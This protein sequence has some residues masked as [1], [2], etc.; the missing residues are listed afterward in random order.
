VSLPLGLQ[1][2]LTLARIAAADPAVL[3]VDEPT[4]DVPPDEAHA[5]EEAIAREAT[6]RAVLFITHDVALVRRRASWTVL[7]CDARVAASCPARELF[8]RPPNEL[9]RRFVTSGNCWRSPADDDAPPAPARPSRRSQPASFRWVVDGR[10]GG[11]ARP[12]LV[13]DEDDELA[14]L[15]DLGVHTLV[16]LEEWAFPPDRLARYG[17]RGE[18]LPMPDMGA[19]E[20]AAAWAMCEATAR[21]LAAGQPTVFHCKAGLGR[22]GTMLAAHLVYG[23]M[24]ALHALEEVRSV[25]TGYVQSDE[26]ELFLEAFARHCRRTEARSGAR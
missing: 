23:G 15:R 10:L 14:A 25:G 1:R 26:Q 18:H 3:L 22:T 13:G 11:M 7:L 12:G 16:T 9:C 2:R 20:V 6:R 4:R 5:I 21:R 19:P 8:E 17:L 24:D